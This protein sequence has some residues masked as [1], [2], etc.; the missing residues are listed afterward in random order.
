LRRLEK[1]QAHT[2][3]AA[4]YQN[5]DTEIWLL[6]SI[7]KPLPWL[8]QKADF[9]IFISVFIWPDRKKE[10]AL[11]FYK[12]AIKI[13]PLYQQAHLALAQLLQQ[14]G[15]LVEAESEYRKLLEADSE[16]IPAHLALGLLFEEQGLVNKALQEYQEVIKI[17]PDHEEAR[18]LINSLQERRGE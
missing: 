6:K 16:N 12:Q 7:K 8:L 10:E 9:S 2:V 18:I 1:T 14:S 13:D 5:K 4:I 11:D 17:N 15:N 3:L